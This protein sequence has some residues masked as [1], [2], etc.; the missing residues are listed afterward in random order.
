MLPEY[1]ENADTFKLYK[2]YLDNTPILCLFGIK[3]D[4]LSQYNYYV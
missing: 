1:L 2:L 3:K 4:A